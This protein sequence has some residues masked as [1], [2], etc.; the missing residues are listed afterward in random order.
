LRRK[1]SASTSHST[2]VS[3][4]LTKGRRKINPS[5]RVT[6][7]PPIME[8]IKGAK[9]GDASQLN[10]VTPINQSKSLKNKRLNSGQW[11]NP[12]C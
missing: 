12:N 4:T 10:L 2:S 1:R 5:L 11:R 8:R 6:R 9:R 7:I 3:W